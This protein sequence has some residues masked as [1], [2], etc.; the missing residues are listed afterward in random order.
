MNEVV[1]ESSLWM[2]KNKKNIFGIGC[3]STCLIIYLQI[4]KE[5]LMRTSS[6]K[7]VKEIINCIDEINFRRIPKKMNCEFT[8]K[9]DNNKKMSDVS[10]HTVENMYDNYYRVDKLYSGVMKCNDWVMV[11]DKK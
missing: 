3:S 7:E 2:I 9:N 5:Q 10:L 4:L 11:K 6:N 8:V 1:C